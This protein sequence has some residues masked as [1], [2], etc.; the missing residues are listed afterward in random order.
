MKNKLFAYI[1][2]FTR[3]H[4]HI[5]CFLHTNS[6]GKKILKLNDAM[7]NFIFYGDVSVHIDNSKTKKPR[8][9]L[10]EF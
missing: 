1:F 9:Y 10:S 8:I 5:Q 2:F 6:C 3:S 7:P 4:V